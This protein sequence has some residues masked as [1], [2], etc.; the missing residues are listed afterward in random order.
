MAL[1]VVPE[2]YFLLVIAKVKTFLPQIEIFP[3]LSTVIITYYMLLF[4]SHKTDSPRA[5][6]VI[7]IFRLDANT[8]TD[9]K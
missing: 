3:K 5:L 9:R 7:L 2:I 8:K 6:A 1:S 4:Q